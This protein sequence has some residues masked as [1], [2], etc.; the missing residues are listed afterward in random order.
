[1]GVA[2]YVEL[3]KPRLSMLVLAT[4]AVGFWLGMRHSLQAPVLLSTLLGTA[5]VVGGANALNQWME[6]DADALMQRTKHR[7][8]PAGRL[9]SERARRFGLTLV[10]GGLVLLTVAVNVLSATLAVIA[11]ISYLLVYTPLKRLTPLCTLAGAIPGALPPMIGWAAARH[12]LGVEAWVL[13]ALL[14]FWQLPHFLAIALLYRDDYERAGFRMLPVIEPE[15]D[16]AARQMVLYGAALLPAS[17]FPTFVGLSGSRYFYG[18]LLLSLAFL[19]LIVRSAMTRSRR[20]SW[21][22]FQASVVYLPLVI[23]LLG[24]DKAVG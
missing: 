1:M 11:A 10:V 6:R 4:T 16:A 21:Q 7:P 12:A 19:T 9:D 14:F 5:L 17:L 13:F 3:T 15:G 8:L 24:W 23:A 22:L 20:T 2:D 18:A